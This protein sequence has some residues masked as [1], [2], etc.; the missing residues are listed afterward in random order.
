MFRLKVE[1][2]GGGGGG[3]GRIEGE[4]VLKIMRNSF[5]HCTCGYVT[6]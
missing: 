6:V 5:L 4:K 3:L 1:E 2:G